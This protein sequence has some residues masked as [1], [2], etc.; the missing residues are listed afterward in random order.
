MKFDLLEYE[1]FIIASLETSMV[2]KTQY[3]TSRCML[4]MSI[5]MSKLRKNSTHGASLITLP[6]LHLLRRI[7]CHRRVTWAIAMSLPSTRRIKHWLGTRQVSRG[8]LTKET[9]LIAVHWAI[10]ETHG[11]MLVPLK[12]TH[13]LC[14]EGRDLSLCA[15][16]SHKETFISNRDE[17][18]FIMNSFHIDSHEP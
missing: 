6:R 17:Y 4:R 16:D 15:P 3:M 5:W 13:C 18:R 14:S 8:C 2:L 1:E 11:Y 9:K 7:G 12:S 10:R